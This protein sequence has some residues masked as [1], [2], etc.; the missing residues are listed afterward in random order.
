MDAGV[1]PGAGGDHQ[2]QQADDE[3]QGGHEHGAEAHSRPGQGGVVQAL[4]R[5]V[6]FLG[7]FDDEDGILGRQADEQH[8]TDLGVKVVLQMAQHQTPRGAQDRHG[9]R[10]QDR[11]GDGPAFVKGY[12]EEVA[13]EHRQAEDGRLDPGALLGLLQGHAGPLE[14]EPLRQRL[15]R[16]RLHGG[17]GLA[18][19]E[20]AGGAAVDGGGGELVVAEH[21]IS[22]EVVLYLR[23]HPD[24]HHGARVGTDIGLA[25]LVHPGPGRLVRLD[26][27]LVGLA[28]VGE[29]VDEGAAEDRLQGREDVRDRYLEIFRLGAVQ[30]EEKLGHV[31]I[32]GGIGRSDAGLLA[33][34][35][36]QTVED[37][38][39]LLG[40]LAAQ[41]FE[42]VGKAAG[43]A[44]TGDGRRREDQDL[45]VGDGGEASLHGPD[46]A[47]DLGLWCVAVV[48]GLQHED[49]QAGVGG[50][51]AG[52]HA[53]AGDG[54]DIGH[55][56]RGAGDRRHLV[57]DLGG[58]R[59]GRPGGQLDIGEED[60]LV[61]VGDKARGQPVQNPHR[62]PADQDDDQ[63]S[64]D[65][66]PGDQS[67]HPDI[68]VAG[69]VQP[70][71]E[72]G[73]GPAPGLLGG[74]Q[75]QGTEHGR[76]G[77]GI[78]SGDGHRGGD[79]E[80]ELLEKA[81][82]DARQEG[83]RGKD[84]EQHQGGGDDGAGYLLHGLE[85][86]RPPVEP[87][88]EHDALDVLHHHDGVVHYQ[89]D[90]QHHREQ[91]DGI[92]REACCQQDDE[93]ADQG[94]GDGQGRDDGRPDIL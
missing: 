64:D 76:Q 30:V 12:Q 87:F 47:A 13:E 25:D 85:G 72:P 16:D 14:A 37:L 10:G 50:G 69:G 1:G 58:P 82:A 91:T 59:Q 83:H 8:Q 93:D 33:R 45:G 2:G 43:I 61:L 79:G 18:A 92:G 70:L 29:I 19:G 55:P 26:V 20:A 52:E 9:D 41:P 15:F 32:E 56:R 35:G 60:A 21:E 73:E 51:G 42:L 57:Q 94:D 3:G 38:G 66:A 31:G 71:I 89:P 22:T 84:G 28:Q 4:A 65:G 80:R 54:E 48:P 49:P 88:F 44:E 7:E 27:D 53:V 34:R 75:E 63:A 46:Q 62:R 86:R 17:H 90:G 6:L 36:H 5:L 68:P 74:P 23:Q 77:Q 11:E 24:G 39:Q 78:D 81:A 67:H 40:G